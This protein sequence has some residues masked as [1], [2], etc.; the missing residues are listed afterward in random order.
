MTN[1]SRSADFHQ[2]MSQFATIHRML[3]LRKNR[4][5][6]WLDNT[7][8][9]NHLVSFY[10]GTNVHKLQINAWMKNPEKI[11]GLADDF[12]YC[13]TCK[14]MVRIILRTIQSHDEMENEKLKTR[15]YARIPTY[16][17]REF[18]RTDRSDIWGKPALRSKRRLIKEI[19][20][21]ACERLNIQTVEVCNGLF[22]SN[23]PLLEHIITNT[24]VN[25]NAVCSLLFQFE[26]CQ[27]PHQAQQNWTVDINVKKPWNLGDIT[28]D[29]PKFI[30]P[31]KTDRDLHILHITDIHHDPLYLPGSL[32]ECEEPLCCQR[33]TDKVTNSSKGAGY[34]GDYRDC[35]LPWHTVDQSLRHM[36][37][38]HGGKLDFIFQTGDVIDHM[39]WSTSI[40][41]NKAVYQRV[42]ERIYELFPNV[43]VYPCIGNHEPH[44][45]NA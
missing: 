3:K 15:F 44:P 11:L 33:Y 39:I 18:H 1:G 12:F 32:A 9:K 4:N 38:Q 25:P 30:Q 37:W 34:W 26:F 22:D 45:L 5:S 20:L 7:I 29:G 24:D 27:D 40:E 10:H 31:L 17:E 28:L 2:V 16:R 36:R 41:K 43:P 8:L 23:W 42:T 35:D 19:I 14:A 6:W 21:D 13:T